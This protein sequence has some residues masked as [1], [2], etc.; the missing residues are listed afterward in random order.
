MKRFLLPL[1][2]AFAFGTLA[3]PSL[4]SAEPSAAA[5]S[6]CKKHKK[7]RHGKKKAEKAVKAP[8]SNI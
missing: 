3:L 5:T 1:V 6:I 8:A 2:A 4:A 7:K